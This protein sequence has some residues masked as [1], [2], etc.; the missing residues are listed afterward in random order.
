MANTNRGPIN[1]PNLGTGGRQARSFRTG[2]WTIIS[3]HTRCSALTNA[4][5]EQ[6][7]S[8]PAYFSWS[9]C[10]LVPLQLRSRGMAALLGT[11]SALSILW[12]RARLCLSFL[13]GEV[14]FSNKLQ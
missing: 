1:L 2:D 14:E 12:Q 5:R 10:S 4:Y 9:A 8:S 11:C 3:G 13:V 7:T 6:Q